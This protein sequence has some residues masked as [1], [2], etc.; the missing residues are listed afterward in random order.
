MPKESGDVNVALVGSSFLHQLNA[1]RGDATG[2][3]KQRRKKL[4]VA[5]GQGI[6][7]NDLNQIE[8]DE[9]VDDPDEP[10]PDVSSPDVPVQV[11][12]RGRK[13]RVE[14]SDEDSSSSG[15]ISLAD[16]DNDEE[17][18]SSSSDE[19]NEEPVAPE[20][21]PTPDYREGDYVLVEYDGQ[22]YPGQII[23][24]LVSGARVKCMAKMG[25]SWRWPARP[26]ELTY[27]WSTV[28]Q[29]ITPPIAI[30]KRSNQFVVSELN[31]FVC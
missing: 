26:D 16:V 23:E 28:L 18:F 17:S 21:L 7:V 30:S 2:V 1:K 27:A 25:R 31:E 3:D 19:S 5:P 9:N 13:R 15:D 12:R 11:Q 6:T 10:D 14:S 22:K 29:K 8:P 20:S 24:K 4:N